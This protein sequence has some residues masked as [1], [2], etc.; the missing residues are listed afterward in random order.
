MNEEWIVQIDFK[1]QLKYE[2]NKG[3]IKDI[4]KRKHGL[5]DFDAL[6][7]QWYSKSIHDVVVKRLVDGTRTVGLKVAGSK[8]LADSLVVFVEDMSGVTITWLDN[9]IDS[10]INEIVALETSKFS[11]YI[12]NRV[13]SGEISKDVADNRIRMWSSAVA[14]YEYNKRGVEY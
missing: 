8:E 3:F 4:I 11:S 2:N 12:S 5:S 7:Q 10:E 1:D 13:M 9:P 14:A 6:T